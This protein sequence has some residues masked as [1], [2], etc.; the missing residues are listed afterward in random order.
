MLLSS[1][2]EDGEVL[3]QLDAALAFSLDAP[4]EQVSLFIDGGATGGGW[5]ELVA[6]PAEHRWSPPEPLQ[7]DQT[8]TASIETCG[9]D[10]GSI[11]F[12][13]LPP[14][15]ADSVVGLSYAFDLLDEDLVW[16]EPPLALA[17]LVLEQ[18]LASTTALLLMPDR[19]G[20]GSIDF[21]AAMG[22]PDGEGGY[23]QH[24]CVSPANLDGVDFSRDPW[25]VSPPTEL[26]LSD[27]GS[28]L[29][30]SEVVVDGVFDQTD[31]LLSMHISLQ[32]DV[33]QIVS[34]EIFDF[35][36]YLLT[37]VY[38]GTCV[39]CS[40]QSDEEQPSCALLEAIAPSAAALDLTLDP[41][42]APG[43]GC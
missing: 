5:V 14:P 13:T 29:V 15:V 7:S 43:E 34:N 12:S 28:P 8:Y 33:R 22:E 36:G 41:T 10:A 21:L 9:E 11:R 3:V 38:G 17:P 2:P 32:L 42:L 30:L 26:I 6:D 25:F 4:A 39:P 35:C 31:A 1:S 16:I 23:T 19:I 24:D 27:R 18:A 40:D 20:D 37:E